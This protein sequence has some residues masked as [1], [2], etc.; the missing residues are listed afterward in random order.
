MGR[1]GKGV[2]TK[3][4]DRGLAPTNNH[5]GLPASLP[6]PKNG[7]ANNVKTKTKPKLT[8]TQQHR[9]SSEKQQNKPYQNPK[10]TNPNKT[11]PNQT[12]SEPEQA[13]TNPKP[14]DGPK[15]KH[16]QLTTPLHRPARQNLRDGH[17]PLKLLALPVLASASSPH[18]ALSNLQCKPP[19][20][21]GAPLTRHPQKTCPSRCRT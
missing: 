9:P 20:L 1:E 12:R 17:D 10:Q 19:Q 2:P 7:H 6:T 3:T 4:S 16:A 8:K 11:P 13:R 18:S 21:N 14:N 5:D 15:T